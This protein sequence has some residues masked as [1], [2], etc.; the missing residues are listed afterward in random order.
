MTLKRSVDNSSPCLSPCRVAK[1]FEQSFFKSRKILVKPFYST[2]SRHI[3]RWLIQSSLYPFLTLDTIPFDPAFIQGLASLDKLDHLV[4]VI[5]K[6]ATV[7]QQFAYSGI[8]APLQFLHGL[9]KLFP[10]RHLPG[11]LG[12]GF[13]IILP[14]NHFTEKS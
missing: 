1:Y 2:F 5:Y 3:L 10:L 8:P 7:F 14:Q 13:W 4:E 9:A 6:R 11:R 12:W